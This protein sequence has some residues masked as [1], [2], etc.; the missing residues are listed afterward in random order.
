MKPSHEDNDEYQRLCRTVLE[1]DGWRCQHC[2]A[3]GQLHVHHQ[4]FRSHGGTDSI[5]NLI[6]LC[7]RCHACVHSATCS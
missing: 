2:G 1:R 4:V 3:R 7:A 5:D 6:T